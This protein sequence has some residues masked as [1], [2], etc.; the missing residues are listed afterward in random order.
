MAEIDAV[1][2]N[3]TDSVLVDGFDNQRIPF[4]F[5]ANLETGE[6]KAWKATP[7]GRKMASNDGVNPILVK[8]RAK[9]KLK[10]LSG[11]PLVKEPSK[12]KIDKVQGLAMYQQVFRF[13]WHEVRGESRRTVDDRWLQKM[14]QCDFLDHFILPGFKHRVS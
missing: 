2:D 5:W 14:Q 10:L 13:T 4:A 12:P 6:W 7:D 1:R 11:A 8:G 3:I 9:G